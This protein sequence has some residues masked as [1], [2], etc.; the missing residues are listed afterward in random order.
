MEL[1]HLRYFVAVAE[2]GHITRAAERLGIQQPPLSQQIQA[3][4]RELDARLFDRKPRGVELTP[5]GRAFFAE[6]KV[7]LA[8]VG[9]A[10]AATQ[11]AARGETGRVGLG[12]TSSASF[13]PFVPRAIRA[14]REAHPGVSLTLEESGTVEL[15]AA[16]RSQALDVAFVRS[17]VGES[18]DLTVRPLLDEA[19]VAALPSGHRLGA[20][21]EPLPLAALAGETFILYRRPVGPG[22]HDAI[23]AACDR[24][25]FSPQIGQEAPRMLSTLSLVAAGLGV[26]LVPRSMSRLEAEGVIYRPLDR[27]T[28]LTAPLN[29]AYRRGESAAAVR[30]FVALVERSAA[31]D[32]KNGGD[33]HGAPQ[34]DPERRAG[35]RRLPDPRKDVLRV[36]A[37]W[38]R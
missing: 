2:E 16:L 26:T 29:L 12:F 10:V 22:L 27:S 4:E 11:R 3:L 30:R 21:S 34:P 23:I 14:F 33:E 15:V 36:R 1:R 35:D 28:P 9:D 17:P 32:S 7:I 31:S 38:S 13:H 19:M 6:A 25:G 24:A 18:A 37:L 20:A 5:A 8:R